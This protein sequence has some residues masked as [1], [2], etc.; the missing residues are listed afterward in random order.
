MMEDV[1]DDDAWLFAMIDASEKIYMIVLGL[2]C[3]CMQL[4]HFA[5][6]LHR[7]SLLEQFGT[8]SNPRQRYF[9]TNGSLQ[10]SDSSLYSS[11]SIASGSAIV[12]AGP[13]RFLAKN[14]ASSMVFIFNAL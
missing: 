9:S 13:K 6:A 1:N 14:H 5:A 2:D 3:K 10:N 12:L 8:K 11:S 4:H 7:P